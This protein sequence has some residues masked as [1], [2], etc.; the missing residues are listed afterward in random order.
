MVAHGRRP[1]VAARV[2]QVSRQAIY[3]RNSNRSVVAG[4]G[5]GRHG[6]DRIVEV[7]RANPVDSTRIFAAL[8]SREPGESVNRK[9]AQRVVRARELHGAPFDAVRTQS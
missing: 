5:T 3:R 4:P 6:D 8:A 1:A 9:R 7:A 2:A